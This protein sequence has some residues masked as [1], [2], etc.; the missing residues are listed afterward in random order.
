MTFSF[1]EFVLMMSILGVTIGC[2][3][4]EGTIDLA[5]R[6]QE[7]EEGGL[8]PYLGADL[9][10]LT[11]VEQDKFCS[12]VE[13]FTNI[14]L[15][16]DE[17]EGYVPWSVLKCASP[18]I[19]YVLVEISNPISNPGI[20]LAKVHFFAEDWSYKGQFSFPT[21][22]RMEVIHVDVAWSE[23]LNSDVLAIRTASTG[24]FIIREGK[25]SPAFE[26]GDWQLQIYVL[27]CDRVALVRLED[28]RKRILPNRFDTSVPYKGQPPL[29]RTKE[30]WI[31]C[32]QSS[33]TST[34]LEAL[35]WLSGIHLP[36]AEGR[37]ED[38]DQESVDDSLLFEQVL[39]AK[40][41]K[42]RIKELARSANAWIRE[43]AQLAERHYDEK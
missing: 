15:T 3:R 1:S 32:L 21:G 5:Y 4:D 9:R 17:F 29:R 41:V 11:S 6:R 27:R 35:V 14:H 12:Q 39:G 31:Q 26:P 23:W 34:V 13:N 38:I 30:Q 36:S 24:P 28:D 25:K 43:G 42:Q 10:K 2:S 33:N 37:Y 22:Y 20:S 19:T 40:R 16:F 8:G 18:G 7:P